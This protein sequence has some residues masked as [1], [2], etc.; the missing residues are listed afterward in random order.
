MTSKLLWVVALC[1]IAYGGLGLAGVPVEQYAATAW[2]W[3]QPNSGP[4]TQVVVIEESKNRSAE[5]AAVVLGPTSDKLRAADKWRLF[6]QDDVPEQVKPAVDTLRQNTP[7]PF[8][9]MFHGE[10]YTVKP[11]PATDEELAVLLQRNGGF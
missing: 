10:S 2:S 7:L 8:V 6:D 4:I 11:L 5:V 9:M 1:G 3:V